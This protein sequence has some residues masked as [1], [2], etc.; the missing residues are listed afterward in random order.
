[1]FVG[2]SDA[3]LNKSEKIE[4][5]IL[6]DDFPRDKLQNSSRSLY[7]FV[8]RCLEKDPDDRAQLSELLREG[9]LAESK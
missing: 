6:E 7:L 9:W 4:K 1:L 5:L 2:F 3:A 8:Q